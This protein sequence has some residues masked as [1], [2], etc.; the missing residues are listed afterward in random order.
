MAC[1]YA[2]NDDGSIFSGNFTDEIQDGLNNLAITEGIN[3]HQYLQLSKVLSAQKPLSKVEEGKG[4]V[5]DEHLFIVTHQAYELWFKQILY[6]VD[7]IRDILNNN[8]VDE[9]MMLMIVTQLNRVNMIMKLLCDQFC[10][11]ETMTPLDFLRFRS[12]LGSS[13]GFQS[14]QFRILENTLGLKDKHRVKYNQQY[15]KDVFNDEE[16]I[17]LLDESARKP[18]LLELVE[19][20]L[21]RTPGLSLNDFNF[22]NKY[23]AAVKQWLHDEFKAPA[24]KETNPN[25][26]ELK[27]AEYNK[28]QNAYTETLNE[29]NYRRATERGER[30]ISHSAF[31]GAIMIN[32]YRD[33]PR[34]HQPFQIL[35][36][37][38][39]LDSHFTKWRYAHVMLVQRMI[40]SKLGTG[41]SSGYH[42]L[43]STVS[44]RYKIF[45]DLFNVSTYMIPRPYIPQLTVSMK[46]TLSVMLNGQT[47][48]TPNTEDQ[49]EKQAISSAV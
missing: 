8:I 27:M 29:D 35:T 24:E 44:D 5:H 31:Q 30:R 7:S 15:Y 39:D 46:R 36:M 43:R 12:F 21:E 33:E 45:L 22:W 3:Y 42:Y 4:S 28:I 13:S 17:K 47:P 26:K 16:S 18:S 20:W 19:S 48:A 38:Q 2:S 6:E 11:L 1:P 34:F 32:L 40:G 23:Q 25:L 10:I 41:G 37:L 49:L 14:L 9:R